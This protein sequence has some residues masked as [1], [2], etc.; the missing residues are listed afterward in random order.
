MYRLELFQLLYY[1]R[2]YP[3]TSQCGFL[4]GNKTSYS[5][6]LNRFHRQMKYLITKTEYV[7][8]WKYQRFSRQNMLTHFFSIFTNGCIDT[9]DVVRRAI[10]LDTSSKSMALSP[11][12]IMMAIYGKRHILNSIFGLESMKVTRSTLIDTRSSLVT[13]II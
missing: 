1:L 10:T 9:V 11:L 2:V 3:M 6:L 5:N 4:F 13:I 12:S 7:Q 8:H